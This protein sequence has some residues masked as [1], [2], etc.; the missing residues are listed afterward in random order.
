MHLFEIA[1]AESE[2]IYNHTATVMLS[3]DNSV[4]NLKKIVLAGK[5]IR[6]NE[7]KYPKTSEFSTHLVNIGSSIEEV[8]SRLRNDLQSVYFGRTHDIVNELRSAMPEGFLR[9]QNDFREE[10]MARLNK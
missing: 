5:L 8:E 1:H 9:N 4:E 7:S 10:M 6:Q 2:W 3:F